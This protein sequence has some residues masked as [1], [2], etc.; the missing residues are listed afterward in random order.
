MSQEVKVINY[1]LID[2]LDNRLEDVK[3]FSPN[4]IHKMWWKN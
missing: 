3:Y 4:I 1:N 2:P